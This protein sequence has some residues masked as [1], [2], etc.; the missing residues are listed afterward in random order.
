MK[1]QYVTLF[2]TVEIPVELVFDEGIPCLEEQNSCALE[3]FI[4][5][6]ALKRVDDLRLYVKT[7]KRD[8]QVKEQ[9]DKEALK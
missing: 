9:W 1:E 7:I 6:P 5:H 8:S 3:N 4:A 2:V